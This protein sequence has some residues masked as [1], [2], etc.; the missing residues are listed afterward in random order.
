MLSRTADHLFWM[1]RYTERAEN[2][3][4]MLDVERADRAAAA[5]G[6]GHRARLARDARHLR[7]AGR[8]RRAS[9]RQLTARDVIDFMARDPANPSSIV[10]CLTSAREN[11]RAVRGT[12]TTEVWETHNTTWLEMQNQLRGS[13]LESDPSR[14]LRM[15][16]VPL[17]PVA[18]RHH[19]HHA[20]GRGVL[21]HPAGHLPGARRQH[22][23]HPRRQVSWRR[24]RQG[25]QGDRTAARTRTATSITGRRCCARCRPSKSTARS[26]AT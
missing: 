15:G 24:Q 4:R 8:L 3:A 5:V 7:A 22:R 16:E 25:Q 14:V 19:R 10:S 11:A 18:R 17:A 9:T 20:A 2:T 26:T 12:L 13:L 21:L 23:A 1:A 6:R